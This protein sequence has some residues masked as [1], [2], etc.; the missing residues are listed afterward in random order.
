MGLE[1]SAE[2]LLYRGEQIINMEKL[3]N[4]AHGASKESDNLPGVF[5]EQGLAHGPVKGLTVKY[6]SAMVQDFYKVMGWDEAGIPT[7]ETLKR[8]K[9]EKI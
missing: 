7:A 1:L 4:L 5:Q 9:L 6:L 2:A 8:L 3:F